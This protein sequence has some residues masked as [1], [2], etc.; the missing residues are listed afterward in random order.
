MAYTTYDKPGEFFNASPTT[1]ALALTADSITLGL[2]DAGAPTTNFLTNLTLAQANLTTGSTAQMVF[3]IVDGI[4]QRFNGILTADKPTKFNL[5][6]NGYTD[7]ATGE[8]VYNYAITC[9]VTPGSLVAVN[10]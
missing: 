9:R 10:S 8:L 2:S 1:A 7:E 5:T 6:R 4:Y 3:G